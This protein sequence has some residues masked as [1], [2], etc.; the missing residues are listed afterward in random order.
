M[1]KVNKNRTKAES[2]IKK[3]LKLIKGHMRILS[4]P[5]QDWSKRVLWWGSIVYL[6]RQFLEVVKIFY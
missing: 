2:K 6:A 4:T 3:T 1:I 5:T